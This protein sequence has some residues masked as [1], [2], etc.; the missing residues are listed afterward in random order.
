MKLY[1]AFRVIKAIKLAFRATQLAIKVTKLEQI[2]RINIQITQKC[3]RQE[4]HTSKKKQE[5]EIV[6][7]RKMYG[8]FEL[9]K[10][11]SISRSKKITLTQYAKQQY[12]YEPIESNRIHKGRID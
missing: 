5:Q 11:H 6:Q 9:I 12:G 10:S 1:L 7:N 2:T 4:S 3:A 8:H